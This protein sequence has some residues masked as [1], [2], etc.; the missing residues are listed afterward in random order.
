M[1]CVYLFY[2][3][4]DSIETAGTA[5]TT[6]VGGIVKDKDAADGNVL[7]LPMVL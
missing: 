6:V 2:R 3:P 7:V 4:R 5:V 1:G